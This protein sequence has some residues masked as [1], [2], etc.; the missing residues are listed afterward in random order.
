MI[1][2]VS[3]LVAIGLLLFLVAAT[4]AQQQQN[5]TIITKESS[6]SSN[7]TS[8]QLK[9]DPMSMELLL[10]EAK[11]AT[12][13]LD[14]ALATGDR[15]VSVRF[16][17]EDSD[18]EHNFNP[19]SSESKCAI[20]QLERNQYDFTLGPANGSKIEITV[21]GSASTPGKQQLVGHILSQRSEG[22]VTV[23]E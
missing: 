3:S 20:L 17:C 7:S 1:K 22:N 18:N 15:S 13:W 5:G 8:R 14:P 9:L 11:H 10:S 19:N 12:L 2:R 23:I 21:I 6:E 4:S 16:T